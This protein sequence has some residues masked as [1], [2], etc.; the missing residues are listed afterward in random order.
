MDHYSFGGEVGGG[1]Q[2]KG[3]LDNDLLLLYQRDWR[4]TESDLL[5]SKH[6]LSREKGKEREQGGLRAISD[7]V[8]GRGCTGLSC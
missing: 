4:E 5:S 2:K 6:C 3:E 1:G 7:T 8:Q